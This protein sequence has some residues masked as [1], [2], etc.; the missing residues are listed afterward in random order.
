MDRRAWALVAVCLL[1]TCWSSPVQV[2]FEKP[3]AHLDAEHPPEAKNLD[4]FEI[5]SKENEKSSLLL[6]AGD[7]IVKPGRSAITCQDSSCFWPKSSDGTVKVPYT[8]S[9]FGASDV[10]KIT[11]AMK[12]F[13]SMTCIRFVNR[14]AETDYVQIS[15]GNGCSSYVGRIGGPQGVQ[16]SGNCMVKGIIQHEL[17]HALGFLHEQNRSDRDDYVKIMFEYIEAGSLP[18]FIKQ[19]TNNL[20]LEYDYSSVMHYGSYAFSTI[21]G[22]KT[23]IPTKNPTAEI[24]QRIGVSNLDIAKINQL[25]KCGTCSTLLTYGYGSLNSP[26]YPSQYPSNTDCSYLMRTSGLPMLLTFSAFDIE[27]SK[28]CEADY[29]TVYDGAT[30]DAPVL[31][32]KACG[33]G[34]VPPVVSSGS[35]MLL[36]FV[37]NGAISASGFS[38]FYQNTRCAHVY[39]TS[40]GTVTSENYPQNYPANFDCQYYIWAPEGNKISL[41]FTDFYLEP[42]EKYCLLDYLLIYNGLTSSAPR[43]GRYCGSGPVAPV[44]SRG[45]SLLL[46]F[47]SDNREQ[48]KGFQATYTFVKA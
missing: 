43:I 25:Y 11:E 27:S 9:G 5:I 39:T 7:I 19:T 35:A 33:R 20:G 32:E 47:H 48:M 26:N 21:Y 8:V 44:V 41:T 14:T 30:K 38:A 42:Y 12:E 37:S 29:V 31:L 10:A 15:S 13:T 24:G 22:Q 23:I 40:T 3:E 34:N 46:Q 18:N 45:N 2:F 4:V 16:L 17:M 6:H 1:S 36:Q 28:N